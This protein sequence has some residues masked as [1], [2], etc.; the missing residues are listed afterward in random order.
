MNKKRI[1]I[2]GA[3]LAGLSAAWHLQ[4]KGVDC[5]IFEKET[6][7]GGLCRSKNI[8]GFTFDYDGHLLHFRHNYTFRL[9]KDLLGGNLAGHKRNTWIYIYDRYIR[10]P[11]QANLYGL[12]AAV[13]KECLL[14]FI[15]ASC[16]NQHKKQEKLN[17]LGWIK[18][19]FGGGI[20]K[21][22]MVPYNRKFWTVPPQNLTCEWLDGF[23]PTPSLNQL[24]DGTVKEGEEEFGYNAHFWYPKRGGIN[25]LPAALAS[26]IKHIYTESSVTRIDLAKK[27]ITI[28]SGSREKFDYLISTL[29]L[30]EIQHL[31]KDMPKII[32]RLFKKLKWN[33]IFNLNLGVEEQEG[34]GRHWVYFPQQKLSFFRVGF[35]H[36]F[37]RYLAPL[38]KGSLYAEVSYSKNKP[39]NKNS[40]VLRVKKDLIKAGIIARL[41]SV[42]TEDINDIK[43]GY[44]IYDINYRRSRERIL[45]FLAKNS[46]ISCG[47]F[48]SWRYMSMEDCL[49][50]G[51]SLASIL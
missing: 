34:I 20:A 26:G 23:I 32:S 49:L 47:R 9:V 35:S 43:Y 15:E 42:L 2:L 29:P 14:G 44:P 45:N 18:Q 38:N 17:F 6:E 39:I 46:M 24:L 16:N 27:E 21:H 1:L 40:I 3:G 50:D 19:A 10:Y 12:P 30:P 13:I 4:R 28:N 48:G 41:D 22:F 37:S 25:Q 51:R 31:A 36:N 33:S 8:A 11:F 5:R 7:I